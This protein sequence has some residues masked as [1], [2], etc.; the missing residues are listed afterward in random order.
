[1][2]TQP[3]TLP[4]AAKA[5]T[6]NNAPQPALVILTAAYIALIGWITLS[7]A[8]NGT[9][10]RSTSTWIIGLLERLPL[11]ISGE[12]WEFALNIGMFMPL[13]LLLVLTFGAR[14]FW[15]AALGGIA[16]SL[17]LEGLQQFIPSRVPDARD[18]L[19]NGLGGIIG[20]FFGLALLAAVP[21]RYKE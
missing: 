8:D 6:A 1:M 9:A 17:S 16:L 3:L 15:V 12:Q 19:A 5:P 10:V 13:G 14:F 21:R 18:L 20:M 7:A 11:G 2:D 4:V